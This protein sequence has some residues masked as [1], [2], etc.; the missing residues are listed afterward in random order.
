MGHEE[1]LGQKGRRLSILADQLQPGPG[2]RKSGIRVFSCLDDILA[3]YGSEA[4]DRDAILAP[5]CAPLTY[6]ALRALVA[7]AVRELRGLG[8][9]PT[10]RV[11]V[12]L[13]I[14][15]ETAV[16]ILAVTTAAVCVPL[17]PNF[18]ADELQRYLGDLQVAALLTRA[19]MDSAA[20]GVAHIL[21]IP[22]IDLSPQPSRAPCVFSLVGSETRRAVSC[23]PASGTDHDAFILMTSGTTA[24]PKMVPLT[25]AGV[26]MSAHNAGAVLQLEPQDRLLN[27]LPLFHAHGLISGLLTAL[28]AGST[29][30]CT[31]RFDPTA[32]FGWLAEFQP[33]WYTAVPSVHRALLSEAVRRKQSV[34]RSS[35]RVVRSA[36]ASLPTNVLRDLE[37]LFGVPVIETYG[38]TEA[39]SQIA[40]NPMGRRKPGSVGRSA[41]ADI[42]IMDNEGRPLTAGEHGEI[43]LRGPTI[44]RG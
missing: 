35:L 36:S 40:A 12:V 31:P 24:Q 42:A 29:V 3:Y 8:I 6:G 34:Q 10:D 4:R 25:Q 33:T 20:R 38:M 41:G 2:N 5:G 26:C 21:G 7:K 39:A 28:A 17:N 27:M 18:T 22:I 30:V 1:H 16:A 11:A 9:G 37:S 15:A 14:G 13:P 19:D 43:A 44:T 23:E 32:F